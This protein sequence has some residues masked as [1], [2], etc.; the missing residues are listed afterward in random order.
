MLGIVI[1]IAAVICMMSVGMG[2]QSDV[3]DKIRTLGANLL[4]VRPGAQTS[5]AT[6]LE[7]G[8]AHTLTDDDAS[9]IRRLVPG[10]VVAAPLLSRSAHLVAGD[11]NWTSLV[12]GIGD[13]YLVAREW[14]IQSGRTFTPEELV[15]DRKVAIIGSDIVGQLFDGG[16]ALGKT[17]RIGRVPFT[18]IGMLATKGQGPAGISQD[19]VVFVPL[20]AAKSRLLGAVRGGT[21][22]ALDFIL[23]KVSG[24]E[25]MPGVADGI[26]TLL[27]QRHRLMRDV[28]N[29][30]S[31]QNPTDVLTARK[32]AV[33]TL[34]TLLISIALVSLAVGGISIMNIMLVSV[35]ERTRE[36]GLRM[37][38]GACRQDIRIQFLAEAVVLALTGGLLGSL[39]GCA[40]ASMIAWRAGWPVVIGPM[41]IILA[42]G[43]ATIVGIVFGLYPAHRASRLDPIVAL[44]CE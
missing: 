35:T 40:A 14:H 39:A 10:V 5:G 29:D 21:R 9:A 28:P 20:S 3:A 38:V 43:F 33:R 22:E 41:S 23:V 17:L 18:I 26:A 11:R 44:R 32:G 8:T 6:R 30:F 42:C 16:S 7:A 24:Q 19:D 1:G 25:S 15:F 2:A 27:R 37:A 13:D 4:L 36:I 31:I 34:G 12:A